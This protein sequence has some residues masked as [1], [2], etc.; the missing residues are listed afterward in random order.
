MQY[1]TKAGFTGGLVVDYPN[2]KKAKKFYLVLMSGSSDEGGKASTRLPAA[3]GVDGE[4]EDE[5][6]VRYEKARERRSASARGKGKRKSVKD[7]GKEWSKSSLVPLLFHTLT[8]SAVLK[9]KEA[10]RQK[11]KDNVPRDSKFTGRKRYVA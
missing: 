1:A 4:E 2:S 5:S 11:G 7:G 10:R 8:D 9:K 6:Q 3:K